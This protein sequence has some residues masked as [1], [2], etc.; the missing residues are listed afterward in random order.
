[1]NGAGDWRRG[2]KDGATLHSTLKNAC[3]LIT[4][5]NAAPAN[6]H[7]CWLSTC[8]VQT[9]SQVK[10]L[11]RKLRRMKR[12]WS[13]MESE[14]AAKA[15]RNYLRD[16]NEC[17]TSLC[18]NTTWT[19]AT[20]DSWLPM[21]YSGTKIKYLIVNGVACAKYHSYIYALTTHTKLCIL[22]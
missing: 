9:C 8:L 16:L 10:V 21:K 15:G 22:K 19:R 6:Q 12:D 13:R 7:L 1:M 14:E 3:G 17:I 18:W 11:S 4:T 20:F 5:I 2:I